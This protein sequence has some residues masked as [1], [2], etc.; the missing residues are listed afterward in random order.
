MMWGRQGASGI[1][2]GECVAWM[3]SGIRKPLPVETRDFNCN[4][5]TWYLCL[6]DDQTDQKAKVDNR[7]VNIFR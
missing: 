7:K 5:K 2:N 3:A 1:E 4:T 6:V